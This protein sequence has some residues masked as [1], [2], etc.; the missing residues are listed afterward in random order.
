M[1]INPVTIWNVKVYCSKTG[2]LNRMQFKREDGL[3]SLVWGAWCK[4]N[5]GELH[6]VMLCNKL[7][8]GVHVS[9]VDQK[10]SEL[11][12]ELNGRSCWQI[13]GF[14]ES[15][16]F[17]TVETGET[18]IGKSNDPK[19]RKAQISPKM[20]YD[21]HLSADIQTDDGNKLEGKFH[22][23]FED[24]RKRGEWFTLDWQHVD[25]FRQINAMYSDESVFSV[26]NHLYETRA[27]K[28]HFAENKNKDQEF[29]GGAK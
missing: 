18:K 25:I 9:M 26:A 5:H 17:M 20:P 21:V 10:C 22:D 1:R 23:I 14:S 28:N 16:Y 19:K 11:A 27:I 4:E 15:V 12:C 29:L 24:S 3:P 8:D 6:E 13:P 2:I 7:M